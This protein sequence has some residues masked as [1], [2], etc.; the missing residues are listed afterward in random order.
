MTDCN[1][2]VCEDS[3][4]VPD[5]QLEPFHYL[6]L[7]PWFLEENLQPLSQVSRPDELL[8]VSLQTLW[9]HSTEGQPRSEGELSFMVEEEGGGGNC[10]HQVPDVCCQLLDSNHGEGRDDDPRRYQRQSLQD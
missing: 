9:R 8:E 6:P 1:G 10:C 3:E 7:V 4:I 5:T 2:R